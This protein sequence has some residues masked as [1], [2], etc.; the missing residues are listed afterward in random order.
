MQIRPNSAVNVE[1]CSNSC[2][3]TNVIHMERPT[4]RCHLG[5]VSSPLEND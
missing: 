5:T 2:H 4:V 1:T 3:V